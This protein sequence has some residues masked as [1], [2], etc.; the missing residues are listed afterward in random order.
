MKFFRIGKAIT[1]FA[2]L[3]LS[4]STF[5]SSC[6][7]I[8]QQFALWVNCEVS[9]TLFN[10]G[11]LVDAFVTRDF[12]LLGQMSLCENGLLTPMLFTPAGL[13]MMSL[14]LLYMSYRLLS[15][16]MQDII[17]FHFLRTATAN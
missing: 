12:R 9:S 11:I 2:S 5:A 10:F 15:K 17:R 4:T 1:L 7:G 8:T 3:F 13:T 16:L 6:N 14:A